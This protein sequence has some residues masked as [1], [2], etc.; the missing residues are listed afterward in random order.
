MNNNCDRDLPQDFMNAEI[1]DSRQAALNVLGLLKQRRQVKQ[2]RQQAI[3]AQYI[4]PD[5][6]F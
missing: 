3:R 2:A 4:R 6:T 1:A 5:E